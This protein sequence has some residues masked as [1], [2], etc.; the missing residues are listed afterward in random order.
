MTARLDGD[1]VKTVKADSKGLFTL[2]GLK[3]GMYNLV[4]EASGY[5]SGVKYGVKIT[6][7]GM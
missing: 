3:A 1:D 5:S 2:Q 6:N 4:F 7:G